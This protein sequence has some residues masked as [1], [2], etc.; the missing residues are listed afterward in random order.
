MEFAD[1]TI[2]MLLDD[3]FAD[4]SEAYKN[5]FVEE[6]RKREEYYFQLIIEKKT[7]IDNPTEIQKADYDFCMARHQKNIQTMLKAMNEK[8]DLITKHRADLV[9]LEKTIEARKPGTIREA[10]KQ[11]NQLIK[12]IEKYI[13]LIESYCITLNHLDVRVKPEDYIC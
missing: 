2:K 3:V 6:I 9:E 7:T 11:R 13:R 5:K 12:D 10:K 4:F 8:R 1:K